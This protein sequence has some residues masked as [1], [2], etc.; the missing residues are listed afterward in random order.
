MAE[1]PADAITDIPGVCT[2][3]V[4]DLLVLGNILNDNN[5][6]SKEEHK[7][8]SR[9]P[10]TMPDPN[11]F[12]RRHGGREAE[13]VGLEMVL[14]CTQALYK[15][16]KTLTE[17]AFNTAM[18]TCKNVV[19]RTNDNEDV[20]NN[21]GNIPRHWKDIYDVFNLAIPVLETLSLTF[22]DPSPGTIGPTSTLMVSNHDTL[23]KDLER[24]ND[25]LVLARN[26]LATTQ[27]VQ[28]LAGESLVDQQVLKLIDLCVRVTAR[29][30]DGETGSRAEQQW[31]NVIGSCK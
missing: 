1:A 2:Q 8:P 5:S 23:M 31:G 29:G 28:N 20:R 30:F 15:S 6:Q 27:G 10:S 24:L 4:Q 21:L 19:K 13:D 11:E 16:R 7:G 25:I 12:R 9:Q 3:N 14:L 26:I 18:H 22:E 17:S